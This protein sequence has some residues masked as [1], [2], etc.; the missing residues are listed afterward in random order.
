MQLGDAYNNFFKGLAKY[1]TARKKGR[2]DRFS[3]SNDQFAI[4]GKSIRIPN[5]GWVRL[6]KLYVLTAKITSATISKR[7]GK[8]FVMWLLKYKKL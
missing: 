5:L 3:L 7:G 1:P 2:D 4:K 6:K 8:W